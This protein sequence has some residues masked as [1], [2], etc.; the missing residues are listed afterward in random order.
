MG[1]VIAW[2]DC[3]VMSKKILNQN[4]RLNHKGIQEVQGKRVVAQMSQTDRF[5]LYLGIVED[6]MLKCDS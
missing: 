6:L 4:L 1:L 3:E 5:A 2:K